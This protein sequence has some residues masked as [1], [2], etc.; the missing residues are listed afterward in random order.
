MG[1]IVYVLRHRRA[2]AA[3]PLRRSLAQLVQLLSEFVQI[4][5]TAHTK[6]EQNR[7]GEERGLEFISEWGW[8]S[9]LIFLHQSGSKNSFLSVTGYVD[10]KTRAEQQKR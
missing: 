9:P 2:A 4:V 3:S 7:R 8:D 6:G 10:I 1:K 5:T